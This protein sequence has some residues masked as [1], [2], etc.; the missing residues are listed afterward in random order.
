MQ[1]EH[2]DLHH[3]LPEF[4]DAIHTLKVG[5]AHFAKLFDTYHAL[6]NKVENLEE[7]DVPVS[8][9]A[10]EEMKKERLK[11]KDQLYHMLVGFRAGQESTTAQ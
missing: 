5:N 8:D 1:V 7:Q 9:F 6:T 11:L 4:A 10:I 3:E 2:H